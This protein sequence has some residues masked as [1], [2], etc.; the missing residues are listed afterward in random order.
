MKKTLFLL[1]L[2][3]A[4]GFNNAQAVDWNWNGD[5]RFRYDSSKTELAS[6]PDKPADD[7]YRLRARFG[8]SPTINDELSAGLRLATGD[9]KNPTSTNQTLGKDFAD[10]AIW[11][12]EAYINY[13]PKALEGKVNVLLGKRDIAKTFNVVKDLVWD[14]DVTIE[15][16]TLQY[17]KD[18]SG[19]QKSGPSLIA[20][21]Y[22]LEN[23]A[24]ASDPCIFAVQGAYMGTVSGADFNL[25][26]SYFDYVHMKNV[27]WWN[28]PNGPANDGKDFRI[29]E[30]FGTLGGKLGG[31]LPATLYAQYAHNTA[32]N[33]DNNAVLA[34]LKLGSDKK[35]GGWTLDGGYFYIEKYAVTPLTDGDRPMSSKYST[36]IK[37]LK[38]GATYQLVQNMTL[39]ATYFHV[40]P[41]DSSLTGSTSDHKNLVQ[42]D[43]AVNF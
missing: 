26:A 25:G 33:S 19:K 29:L 1:G 11:L 34:G 15:G 22:T 24:T 42:A 37:G 41:V 28:S 31:S 13:H 14:S 39:G 38:I 12:D 36:D 23:Y 35:P 5:I 30:V 2:A 16:A 32:L 43:V 21:Y 10:K 27:A 18:V 3:T 20:G 4:M 17:G 7:R 9:G 40:N 8:V 6:S